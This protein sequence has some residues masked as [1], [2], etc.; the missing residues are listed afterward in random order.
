MTETLFGSGGGVPSN[1]KLRNYDITPLEYTKLRKPLADYLSNLLSGGVPKYEGPRTVAATDQ[2]TSLINQLFGR[3]GQA[4]EEVSLDSILSQI[5]GG[6]TALQKAGEASIL[7]TLGG[8][9]LDPSTNPW[10]SKTVQAAEGD[11][12]YDWENRI[13][14]NL[15]TSFTG[16]GH[17]VTPGSYGSS[18]FDRSM[19]LASNEQTRQLQDLATEVYSKNYASERDRMLQALGLQQSE[20]SLRAGAQ[21]AALGAQQGQEGIN[22]AERQAQTEELVTT[23]QAV[24]LPRLIEQYGVDVGMQEFR[25]QM[26]QLFQLLGLTGNVSQMQAAPGVQEAGSAGNFGALLQG[27]GSIA[28]GAA[29]LSDRRLKTGI[30]PLGA[31]I[32]H[33]PLY[34]FAYKWAPRVRRWGVMAQDAPVAARIVL[35]SGFLVVNYPALV[36]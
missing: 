18:P 25:D 8:K 28:K 27:A 3:A 23:L 21:D 13:M 10:L 33:V 35:P 29:A 36:A 14:P 5:A 26:Q 1:K 30:V 15:R 7:D 17:T 16:A 20:T 24:A 22:L 9:Y 11:L 32:G 12:Q 4:P 2:E 6:G 34:E 19:A 31:S